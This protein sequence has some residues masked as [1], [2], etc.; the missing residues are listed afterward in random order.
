[1]TGQSE[2]LSVPV[3]NFTERCRDTL[4]E[5]M[6]FWVDRE[7]GKSYN[8]V[9]C[10]LCCYGKGEIS[11]VFNCLKIRNTETFGKE[12]IDAEYYVRY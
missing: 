11:R 12:E 1:M 10:L 6:F 3:V 2:M 8:V 9:V 7:T 4:A 5:T